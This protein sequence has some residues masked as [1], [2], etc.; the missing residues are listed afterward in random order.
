LQVEHIQKL[1]LWGPI[2]FVD[3]TLV[4]YPLLLDATLYVWLECLGLRNWLAQPKRTNTDTAHS[5]HQQAAS[6]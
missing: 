2:S 4:T 6:H 3:T 5:K 1:L